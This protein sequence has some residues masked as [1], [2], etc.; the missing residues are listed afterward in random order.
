MN[1]MAFHDSY[2]SLIHISS[3]TNMIDKKKWGTRITIQPHLTT[4][5][6]KY[7]RKYLTNY[8]MI[9][10][11]QNIFCHIPIYE[12]EKTYI[13]FSHKEIIFAALVS[14]LTI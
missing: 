12:P 1:G 8:A 4:Q 10:K 2:C 9:N 11:Y 14:N 7:I 6:G 5:L 3:Q 13:K